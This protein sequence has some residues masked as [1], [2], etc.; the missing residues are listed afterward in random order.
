MF[1]GLP[2][3]VP[4]RCVSLFSCEMGL[5]VAGVGVLAL[6][7]G[8]VNAGDSDLLWLNEDFLWG[9]EER[10]FCIGGGKF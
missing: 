10:L 9:G 4:W 6:A 5:F 1:G 3:S 7:R 8:G 2:V